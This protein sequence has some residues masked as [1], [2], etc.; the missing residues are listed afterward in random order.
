MPCI[1]PTLRS[2]NSE[3]SCSKGNVHLPDWSILLESSVLSQL[4]RHSL[5]YHFSASGWTESPNRILYLVSILEKHC[6]WGP[7]FSL[8]RHTLYQIM[9]IKRVSGNNSSWLTRRGNPREEAAFYG[10]RYVRSSE[11]NIEVTL[12]SSPEIIFWCSSVHSSQHYLVGCN[13][14]FTGS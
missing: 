11:C 13:S 5:W 1:F 6:P 10:T 7:S 8:Y 14:D 12:T 9:P 3:Q 4:F 2:R